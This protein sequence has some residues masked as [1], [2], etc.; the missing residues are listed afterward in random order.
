M[1]NK[2]VFRVEYTVEL[3]C[4]AKIEANSEEEAELLFNQCKGYDTMRG[5]QIIDEMD[6]EVNDISED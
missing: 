5:D 2:K 1:S 4:V 6:C 3:V